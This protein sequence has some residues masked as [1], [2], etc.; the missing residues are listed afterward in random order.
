MALVG[1]D[2]SALEAVVRADFRP[3]VVVAAGP[4]GATEPPLLDARTE[5]GGEPA[6]YVCEG[7]TCKLP[8]TDPEAL[9]R[10][11]DEARCLRPPRG[12]ATR[13]PSARPALE[14]EVAALVEDDAAA[15]LGAAVAEGAGGEARAAALLDRQL[16]PERGGQ[17]DRRRAG[18]LVLAHP[19][20]VGEAA[21]AHRALGARRPRPRC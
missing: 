5:V 21:R 3:N 4:A 9:G 8:V 13:D 11:L 14:L 1:A 2:P 20:G 17:A 18:R 12:G 16:A 19:V 10:E 6:A 15:D 7:F